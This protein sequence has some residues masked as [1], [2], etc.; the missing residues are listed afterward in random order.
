MIMVNKKIN[1]EW[2]KLP[3]SEWKAN[4]NYLKMKFFIN[5]VEVT[6]AQHVLFGLSPLK[7]NEKFINCTDKF[8]ITFYIQKV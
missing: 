8:S 4:R 3:S 6:N 7:K 1:G 5:T 2:L